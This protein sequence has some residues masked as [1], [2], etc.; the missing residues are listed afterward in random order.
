MYS[1]FRESS[2]KKHFKLAKRFA[3]VI[4]KW[5]RS[6][7]RLDLKVTVVLSRM[8]L[9]SPSH[10]RTPCSLADCQNPNV[11]H[12]DALLD[13]EADSF[14]GMKNHA[15]VTKRFELAIQYSGKCGLIQD[16]ALA[17]ERYSEYL[18]R[19]GAVHDED[20]SF[21]LDEAVRLY[22]EWG[23]HAKVKQ[24]RDAHEARFGSIRRE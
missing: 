1:L 22:A 15:T 8:W 11:I 9:S 12:F 3:G 6:G 23:A 14:R 20:A 18:S 21:Q 2:D 7:V 17:H 16:R 4:K 24:L 19:L 10:A 13:A 5:A